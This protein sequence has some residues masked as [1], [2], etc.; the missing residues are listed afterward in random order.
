[1][2]IHEYTWVYMSIHHYNFELYLTFLG[3]QITATMA[4]YFQYTNK[5]GAGCPMYVPLNNL[6]LI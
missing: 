1:M 6:Q 2:G 4:E 5:K 3:N